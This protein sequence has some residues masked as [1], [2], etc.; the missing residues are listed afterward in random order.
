MSNRRQLAQKWITS[1]WNTKA[2][3]FYFAS[4]STG[5]YGPQGQG[6][7]RAICIQVR[8]H[9]LSFVLISNFFISAE[10]SNKLDSKV[11][12]IIFYVNCEET[13]VSYYRCFDNG[14]EF[15]S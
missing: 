3:S 14:R 7:A 2:V 4:W 9:S 15:R 5:P 10:I 6:E 12:S 1:V 11:A 13:E 8:A